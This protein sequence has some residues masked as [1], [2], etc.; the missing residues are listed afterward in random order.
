[1][2]VHLDVLGWL[3]VLTGAFGVLTGASLAV[4]ASG[5][6]AAAIGGIAGPLA[7][8]AIWL[9]VGC[10][11]VLLAGG[12]TLIVIG[13]RLAVRTR[14]GRLAA[15]VAAVPLLAVPPFG[16]A[17]GIYTFWTLVNDDARRA[18]GQPPPTPDTIRI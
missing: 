3:Y 15:L 14:R 11:W 7:G 16:T 1:V 4:L 5:T 9:L 18:F 17:L 10:G 8:P 2:R 12:I 13:R 6:H